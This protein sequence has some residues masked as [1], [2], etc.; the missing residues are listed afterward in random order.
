MGRGCKSLAVPPLSVGTKPAKTT[1]RFIGWE[2]AGSRVNHEPEY[3]LGGTPTVTLVGWGAGEDEEAGAVLRVVLI[4]ALRIFF[5]LATTDFPN[6]PRFVGILWCLGSGA[7][8]LL[9]R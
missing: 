5:D 1:V 2:G 9:A 7:H 4:K 8:C 6:P 3:L